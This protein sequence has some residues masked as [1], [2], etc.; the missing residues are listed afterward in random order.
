MYLNKAKIKNKLKLFKKRKYQKLIFKDSIFRVKNKFFY[1]KK[2]ITIYYLNKLFLPLK[3][4][5]FFFFKLRK[6]SRR[7]K[8][9]TYVNLNCNHFFSKKSKNSRMGKGTGKFL[10]FVFR[11]KSLKPLFIFYKMSIKRARKF[12]FFLNKK[13]KNNFFLFF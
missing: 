13:S 7:K 8:I 12:I 1:Y 5:K 9:K 4:Y 2:Y 11:S 3:F 10:R 6:I